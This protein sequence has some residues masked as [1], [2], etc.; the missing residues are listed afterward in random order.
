MP[1]RAACPHLHLTLPPR[2]LLHGISQ[3]SPRILALHLAIDLLHKR[4]P[5]GELSISSLAVFGRSALLSVT[6]HYTEAI[7]F[8][9]DTV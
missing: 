5:L 6:C 1:P 9:I 8:Y 2:C 4:G 3:Q 7:E